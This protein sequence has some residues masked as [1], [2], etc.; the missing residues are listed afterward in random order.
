MKQAYT[1]YSCCLTK[2]SKQL[3]ITTHELLA[4]VNGLG[5]GSY[6]WSSNIPPNH[7]AIMLAEND[8]QS[9]KGHH[10]YFQ[11][12]ELCD[13]LVSQA[14][15][16]DRRHIDFLYDHIAD[17]MPVVFHFPT[18][19][20]LKSFLVVKRHN[21]LPPTGMS[22]SIGDYICASWEDEDNEPETYNANLIYGLGLYLACFPECI[23]P[24]VP[25]DLKHPSF[26]S[27][28]KRYT[29]YLSPS[30]QSQNGTRASPCGHFRRGHFRVLNSEWF[31]KK[32]Y[33]VVFIEH[34]YVNGRAH[35]VLSPEEADSS[36]SSSA[37]IA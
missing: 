12:R 16:N 15:M 4:E 10:I 27:G 35:T 25:E 8:L 5:I 7:K 28:G 26:H 29:M 33:Q 3:G 18:Q 31:K 1:Q 9:G 14:E 24:G 13:W 30:I 17:G 37:S 2:Y 20:G 32:R 23:I 36:S 6:G 34:T 19:S 11:Q 22:D 21:Y